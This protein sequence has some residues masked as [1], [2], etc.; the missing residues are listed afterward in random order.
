MK[1]L[2]QQRELLILTFMTCYLYEGCY[3]P[4]F[5]QWGFLPGSDN[6]K[7]DTGLEPCCVGLI[8]IRSTNNRFSSLQ[9]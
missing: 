5:N 6:N 3:L 2:P 1:G 9:K 7:C 4:E 8:K